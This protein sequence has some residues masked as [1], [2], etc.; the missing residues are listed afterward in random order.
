MKK[1]E[2]FMMV[3]KYTPDANAKPNEQQM[4]EVHQAW[5]SFIG[6]I[7]IQE[8]LVSTHKLGSGG[9]Q[10]HADGSITKGAHFSKGKT[11]SGNMIVRANSLE[12]ATE[13]A[14]HSPILKMGGEVEVR[15]IMPMES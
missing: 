6:N 14:M 13:M 2:I 4:A 9:K 12:E 1:E 7:A 5:G 3:F 10:I 8:K 11:M 15:S